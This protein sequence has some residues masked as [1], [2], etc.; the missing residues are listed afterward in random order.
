MVP[1]IVISQNNHNIWIQQPLLAAEMFWVEHLQW[2]YGVEL[3][4]E[5]DSIEVAF[6]PLPSADIMASVKAVNDEPDQVPLK[7]ASQETHC[8]FGTSPNTKVADFWF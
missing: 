7:E 8:T 5:G 4:Q 1:V 2:D 6:Q 3:H